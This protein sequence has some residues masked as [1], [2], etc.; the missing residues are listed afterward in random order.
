MARISCHWGQSPLPRLGVVLSRGAR[1]DA[2]H[3]AARRLSSGRRRPIAHAN[4][5]RAAAAAHRLPRPARAQRTDPA[6]AGRRLALAGIDRRP[7]ADQSPPRTAPPPEGWPEARRARRR[8]LAHAGVAW[9]RRARSWT[10]WPS[11]AA[12]DRGLAAIVAALREAAALYKGDLL[13]DCAGEWI[14]ADRERLRQRAKQVLHAAGRTSR[15][16]ARLRGG[17][18]A[19]AAAACGSIRSTNRPGAR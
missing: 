13:P 11:N 7:G 17:D 5:E 4:A 18:R 1:G 10:S 19:R 14:D 3:R 8:R 16:G 15:T 9:R 2:A 6:S 12:A